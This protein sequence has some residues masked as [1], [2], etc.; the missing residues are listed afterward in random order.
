MI[1]RFIRHNDD[2]QDPNWGN[3]EAIGFS[4][5]AGGFHFLVRGVDFS[6]EIVFRNW[7]PSFVTECNHAGERIKVAVETVES[8]S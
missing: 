2:L 7:S 3:V 1:G 5:S 4:P 6:G 8:G